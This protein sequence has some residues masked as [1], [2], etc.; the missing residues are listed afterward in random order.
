MKIQ[1]I[2]S[3][4]AAKQKLVILFSSILITLFASCHVYSFKDVSIPPEV[5]TVKIGMIENKARYVD[6]QLAP[7]LRD[8]VE[9]KITGQTRLTRTNNDDA[10]YQISGYISENNITTAGISS[11][12]AATNRLTIGVHIVFR[13]T[14]TAKTEEYDVSRN[15]DFSANLTRQQAENQLRD[16]I[17][18]NLSDEIFNRIFSNW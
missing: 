14:L 13:N 12:Q 6:P 16:E 3:V 11:Q 7:Q 4:T 2:Y 18:R 1:T 8:R 10:H 17:L 5:K 9:Q 15:F